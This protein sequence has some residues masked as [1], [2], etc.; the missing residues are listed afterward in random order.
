VLHLIGVLYHTLIRRDGL[1]RRMTF[2]RPTVPEKH[3]S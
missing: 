3:L 1:L 2:A